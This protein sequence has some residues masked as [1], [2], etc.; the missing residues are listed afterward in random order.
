MAS[1]SFRPHLHD[2]TSCQTG[3]TTGWMFVYT[4]QPV[5]WPV[6]QLAVSCIQTFNWLF[7]CLCGSTAAVEQPAV[8]CKQTFNQLSNQLNSRFDNRL[9]VG[10]HDAAGCSTGLT[11]GCIYSVIRVSARQCPG[12]QGAWGNQLFPH[13]FASCWAIFK[14]VSKQHLA[15]NL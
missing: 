1:S 5:W 11:T 4:M 14:I 10:L 3:W 9:N 6:E 2:T 7:N 12:T 8:S 15:E 13:I